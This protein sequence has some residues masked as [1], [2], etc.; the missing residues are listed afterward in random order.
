V[1]IRGATQAERD[2]ERVKRT[3][4]RRSVAF[5]ARIRNA[6]TRKRQL[7]EACQYL[8]A[9]ADDLPEAAQ[10]KIANAVLALANDWSP[11]R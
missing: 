9:V 5:Q 10:A 4:K 3:A 8:R 2:A 6:P 7:S 11:K 1:A